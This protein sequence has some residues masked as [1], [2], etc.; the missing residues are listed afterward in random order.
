MHCLHHCI[1]TAAA[2]QAEK[3]KQGRAGQGRA[4]Q[5][6]AGQGRAGQGRAGQGRMSEAIVTT[7]LH[8]RQK[9]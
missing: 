6:R 5:G 9:S 4:G 3:F 8:S 1:A 7:S 2:V